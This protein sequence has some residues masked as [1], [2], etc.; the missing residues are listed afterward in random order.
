MNGASKFAYFNSKNRKQK[1]EQPRAG[2][3]SNLKNIVLGG[4]NTN[5]EVDNDLNIFVVTFDTMK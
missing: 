5:A 1:E 4:Y 2:L 3:A